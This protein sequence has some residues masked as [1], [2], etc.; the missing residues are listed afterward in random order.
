[1]RVLLVQTAHGLNAP[2]GGYRSNVGFLRQ[3]RSYGHAVAQTCYGFD[4]EVDEGAAKAKAKGIDP[5]FQRLPNL[6]LGR[7]P[8]TR[9]KRHVGLTRFVDEDRVL[10]I[11]ISRTLWEK[12]PRDEQA[13]D[14]K[15]YLE[16]IRPTPDLAS[17]PGLL[18]RLANVRSLSRS[19]TP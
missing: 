17:T 16:V 8:E 13:V 18:S 1:M 5:E 9:V 7:D 6:D 14:Q 11:V 10:N 12:Y 3:L 19:G 4:D 2:S 15:A